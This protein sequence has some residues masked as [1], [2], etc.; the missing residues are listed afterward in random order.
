MD[1]RSFL[2]AVPHVAVLLTA[3]C[4]WDSARVPASKPTNPADTAP[5]RSTGRASQPPNEPA[6]PVNR[7]SREPTATPWRAQ[8]LPMPPE[9][10]RAWLEQWLDLLAVG[11]KSVTTGC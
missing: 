6:T 10:D 11:N 4:A 1:R 3:A 7:A 2:C 9:N 5:V 8:P